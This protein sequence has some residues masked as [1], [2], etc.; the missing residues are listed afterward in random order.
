MHLTK[1]RLTMKYGWAGGEAGKHLVRKIKWVFR[2]RLGC[3]DLLL[4]FSDI[5]HPMSWHKTETLKSSRN[6]KGMKEHRNTH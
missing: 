4:N 1:G 2:E 3:A 6:L 5:T